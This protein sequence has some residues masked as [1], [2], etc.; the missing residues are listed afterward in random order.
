MIELLLHSSERL[1]GE[2]HKLWGRAEF[3]TLAGNLQHYHILIWL[4]EESINKSDLVQCSEKHILHTLLKIADSSLQLIKDEVEMF[5]LYDEC[6]RLHT[7]CCE[8]ANGRC[9]KRK[10]LEG[11]KICRTPPFPPSHTHWVMD[12]ETQYPH[13]ALEVLAKMKL[14]EKIPGTLFGLRPAGPLKCEKVMYAA[15]KGEHILPTC[16]VLFCLT[17]SSTNLL[18]TTERFSCSYLSSYTS[19]TKAC[20]WFHFTMC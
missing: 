19:K 13:E 1:L 4:N 20:R 18:I 17:R 16:G 11:N 2:I 15:T 14:A 12:I 9:K 7:H 6:I 10:D 8:K 3:Q 5:Q